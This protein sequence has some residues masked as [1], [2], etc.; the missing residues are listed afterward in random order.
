MS[1]IKHE[2]HSI[3]KIDNNLYNKLY[4][5][6]RWL[7]IKLTNEWFNIEDLLYIYENKY[8]SKNV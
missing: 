3:Q 4:R 2:F 8:F 1:N 5:H 6:K 7:N